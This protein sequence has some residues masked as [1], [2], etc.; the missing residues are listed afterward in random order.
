MSSP[1]RR[2][3]TYA[4]G[5]T[6]GVVLAIGLAFAMGG[7]TVS[8][9]V[10]LATADE[11]DDQPE[12]AD[13]YSVVQGDRCIQ[14]EPLGDGDRTVEEFYDHRDPLSDPSS[15]TYSSHGTQHLQEDDT[16]IL[17]LHE[18]TDGLSLVMVHDQYD[19][20]TDGG[21]VTFQIDGLPEDGEWV[22]EDDNYSG[23][24]D[25]DYIEA[26][27]QWDHGEDWSRITWVWTEART[28]GGAFNGGLD[29]EFAIE[30]DPAFNDEADFRYTNGSYDGEVTDWELLSGDED[31]PER[32]SLEMDQPIEIRS[33]GCTAVTDIDVEGSVEQ[34]AST[35][36][37]VTVANDGVTDETVT[38]PVTV[39]GEVV[40]EHRVTVD[41]GG[42]ETVSS[43]VEFESTGTVTVSAGDATADVSVTEADE[44]SDQLAGFGIAVAVTAILV[45][46]A[47]ARRQ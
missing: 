40:D 36:V 46:L 11:H 1:E 31:D 45:A 5:A 15:Y 47:L 4:I 19:G 37:T 34:D 6:V 3:L 39:D 44:A 29:D 17:M 23:I 38:V 18:G 7:G 26:D 10:G 28:D 13:V 9:D 12:Q 33:G 41:G 24:V 35:T 32:T 27:A 25:G 30:I 16:S 8:T 20:S 43:T 2:L 14:I 21:S 22:V 42:T